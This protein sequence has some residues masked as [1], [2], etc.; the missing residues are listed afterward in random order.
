MPPTAAMQIPQTRKDPVRSSDRIRPLAALRAVRALIRNPDDTARVFDVIEALSGRTRAR[1]FHRFRKDPAGRRLLD[2]RPDLLAALSDRKRLLE[3]APGTLGRAYAEFMSRE[4]ISADGLVDAS[5]AT[6][7]ED[8]SRRAPLVRGS[9]ARHARPL[10]RRH[11]LPA[12][13]DRRSVAL[14]L[15]LRADPQPRHRFHC[16]HGVLEGGPREPRGAA[17]LARGLPARRARGLAARASRG[18]SCSPSR[19]SRCASSCGVGEPPVYAQMR[20]E[21]AP[22]PA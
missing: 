13:P 19:S 18:R 4:Q 5:T 7:A 15:H 11:R 10:A 9:A 14:G 3:L 17:A 16:R 22:V 21:G 20:S 12:R 1:L 6:R 8:H 2:A